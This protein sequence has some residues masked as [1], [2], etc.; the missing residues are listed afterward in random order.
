MKKILFTGARSGIANDVI[1]E[2]INKKYYIYVTVHTEKQLQIIS[3]KYEDYRN[4]ECFK[5]DI[6]NADDRRKLEELDIDILVNNAAVGYG[7][8][9]AEIPMSKVR[10]N[11]EVN[12]FSYFEVEQIIL[13]NMIKRNSG[14]IINIASIA[15]IIPMCFLGS[16]CAT[17]ASIIKMTECLR[18]ELK[19]IDSKIDICLIEP[20]LYHTGFNQVMLDNKYK[21]MDINSYFSYC[22]DYIKTKENFLFR[23]FEKYEL[24]SI[25]RKI[26]KAIKTNHP[27]FIYRAPFSQVLIAKGYQIFKG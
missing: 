18:K 20:G 12:V 2:I 11:F 17:K 13:K 6:T 10:K 26:V 7:G 9:I 22:I 23:T 3:K 25:V 21:W 15:G 19:L 1:D 27:D 5:L 4:V 14:K 8:S 16:Y 24:K